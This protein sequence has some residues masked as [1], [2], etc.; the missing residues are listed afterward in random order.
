MKGPGPGT[1]HA[2]TAGGWTHCT[3]GPA[4]LVH[5]WLMEP[6]LDCELALVELDDTEA[7]KHSA[8]NPPG[9]QHRPLT[10]DYAVMST[11]SFDD[12]I[13]ASVHITDSTVSSSRQLGV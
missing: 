11:L 2:H 1:G 3:G 9:F 13:T 7:T 6:T 12:L 8:W 5:V 10:G 4:A